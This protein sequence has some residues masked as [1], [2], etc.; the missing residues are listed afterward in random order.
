MRFLQSLKVC[1]SV[2]TI[3]VK[4]SDHDIQMSSRG[5]IYS[6]AAIKR[7]LKMERRPGKVPITILRSFLFS[8]I[9]RYSKQNCLTTWRLDKAVQAAAAA[10]VQG[11]LALFDSSS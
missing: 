11:K 3:D 2:F 6:D 9:F 7:E 8:Q 4:L 5:E 10:A 1:S